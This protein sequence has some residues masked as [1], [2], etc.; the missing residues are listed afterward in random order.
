MFKLSAWWTND[1]PCVTTAKKV[2]TD[3][4]AAIYSTPSFFKKTGIS[5][6]T[7]VTPS[8]VKV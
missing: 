2:T 3:I 5:G 7:L 1:I 8:G 4:Y 6:R